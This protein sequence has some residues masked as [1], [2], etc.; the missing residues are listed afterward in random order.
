MTL[1]FWRATAA[2]FVLSMV[3][4]FLVHGVWLQGDY[5]QLPN[6]MRTEAEA[7]ARFGWMLGAHVVLSG[8]FVWIY[9]QGRQD[10]PWL[11]QG[12]R[13][14]L[15]VALVSSVPM[16]LIYYVVS[17]YPGMVVAKQILGDGGS[18]LA[19]GVVVAWLE[20]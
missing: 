11:G 6:L 18:A 15:A 7:Q 16:F 1:R 12:L 4:G 10:K 17:P 14:G 5:A 20:R 8:A 19:L 3:L 13:F 2:I 9:Q